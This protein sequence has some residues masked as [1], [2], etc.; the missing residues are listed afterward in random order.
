MFSAASWFFSKTKPTPCLIGLGKTLVIVL[1]PAPKNFK[2]GPTI[3]SALA[4][5]VR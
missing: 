5:V 2:T 4:Y 1:T 3:G